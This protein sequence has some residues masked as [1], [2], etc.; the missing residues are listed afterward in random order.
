MDSPILPLRYRPQRHRVHVLYRTTRDVSTRA[1][2]RT[3]TRRRELNARAKT[4]EGKK[5]RKKE[6]K[7]KRE[8]SIIGIQMEDRI[9]GVEHGVQR[10]S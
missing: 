5:K 9:R 10:A 2:F 1:H 8:K 4:K 7:E 3:Y 6:K